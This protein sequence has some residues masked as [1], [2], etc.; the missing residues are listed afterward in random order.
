MMRKTQAMAS[1]L[2]MGL[3]L[4][5]DVIHGTVV[6]QTSGGAADP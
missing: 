4:L 6:A 5:L 2:T 1:G 3:L